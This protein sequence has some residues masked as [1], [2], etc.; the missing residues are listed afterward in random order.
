MTKRGP[1]SWGTQAA[2]A[3]YWG[4]GQ[5]PLV[6]AEISAGNQVLQGLTWLVWHFS[7]KSPLGPE[8]LTWRWEQE[9]FSVSALCAPA[10]WKSDGCSRASFP[11]KAWI[12]LAVLKHSGFVLNTVPLP[13]LC[14]LRAVQAAPL[15]FGSR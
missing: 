11:P 8:S 2:G 3:P 1:P 13:F 5:D 9:E 4:W 15:L 12:N 6:H 7:G 14:T 10:L